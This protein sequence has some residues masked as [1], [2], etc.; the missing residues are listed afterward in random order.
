MVSY[1]NQQRPL[2]QRSF[3]AGRWAW[4]FS[5]VAGNVFIWDSLLWSGCLGNESLSGTCIQKREKTKQNQLS[6]RYYKLGVVLV[7][8]EK[9][10]INSFPR[11][12]SFLPDLAVFTFLPVLLGR[13]F[14]SS[15]SRALCGHVIKLDHCLFLP[16]C[17]EIPCRK[18]LQRWKHS[19][20]G[21]H[22]SYCYGDYY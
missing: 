9:I 12:K 21:Y 22:L 8:W 17:S 2:K 4:L 20:A 13:F 15:K 6:G 10:L 19:T 14:F 7:F 11:P 3:S 16:Q 5:P 1:W 18:V